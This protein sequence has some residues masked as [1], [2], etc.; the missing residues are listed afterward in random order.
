MGPAIWNLLTA[1]TAALNVER[2]GRRPLFLVSI[3]GMMVSY[4]LVMALSAGF[5]TKKLP[6]LGIAVIPFLFT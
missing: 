2:V 4:S 3:T 6:S 5:A 1:L